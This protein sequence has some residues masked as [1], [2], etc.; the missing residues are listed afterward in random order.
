M[1]SLSPVSVERRETSKVHWGC[2]K[3]APAWRLAPGATDISPRGLRSQ[4]KPE[5][6]QGVATM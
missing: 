2:G 4:E 3:E 5:D 1:L 6:R